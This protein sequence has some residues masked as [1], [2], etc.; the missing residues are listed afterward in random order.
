[1]ENKFRWA[2]VGSG[3]MAGTAAA[4]I[5]SS[6]RHTIISVYSRNA[7]TARNI[8]SLCDAISASELDQAVD[9]SDVDGV[10]IAVPQNAHFEYIEKCLN[11][12]KNVLV[13][14]PFTA[15][16]AEAEKAVKLA[17]SKKLLL[18]EAMCMF[19]NPMMREVLDLK[20]DL[21]NITGVSVKYA[22]ATRHLIRMPRLLDAAYAGGSL[23]E[24]G[25]YGVDLCS[26][27][28]KD[29]GS[30]E[31]KLISSRMK[32]GVDTEE[33]LEL[34]YPGVSARLFFSLDRFFGL[35]KAVIK[36]GNGCITIPFFSAPKGFTAVI[37]KKKIKR[38]GLEGRYIYEFDNFVRDVR[39]GKLFPDIPSHEDI[40][41]STALMDQI[42]KKLGVVFE[43]D[44]V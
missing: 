41:R 19:Q 14:K 12:G 30:P 2:F 20:K 34:V 42:R 9:R 18:S 11:L 31:I 40:L 35:P 38:S 32:N 26:F 37:G 43:A 3:R 39:E 28:L 4:E 7:D 6:G 16:L 24:I 36:A 23:M 22:M 27:L 5:L 33:K 44:K 29:K 1:M 8:A 10:Y 13:E 17:A 15:N 25:V 21:G